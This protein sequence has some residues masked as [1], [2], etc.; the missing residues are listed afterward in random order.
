[1][2]WELPITFELY[3]ADL[4]LLDGFADRVSG[5]SDCGVLVDLDNDGV[6]TIIKAYQGP[7]RFSPEGLAGMITYP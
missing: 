1:M 6:N 7:S 3:R 4:G 2:Q 5:S